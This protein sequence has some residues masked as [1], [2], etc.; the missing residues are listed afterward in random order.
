MSDPGKPGVKTSEFWLAAGSM[1]MSAISTLGV[2]PPNSEL[3]GATGMIVSVLLSAW[4]GGQYIGGRNGLKA[5]QDQKQGYAEL[6]NL[7]KQLAQPEPKPA[8]SPEEK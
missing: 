3:Q 7:V 8:S 6:L 1:V 4:F 5:T 2:M